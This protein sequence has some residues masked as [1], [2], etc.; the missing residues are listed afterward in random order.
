LEQVATESGQGT[1]FLLQRTIKSYGER[2]IRAPSNLKPGPREKPAPFVIAFI[3]LSFGRKFVCGI[4]LKVLMH[5]SPTA[6]KRVAGRV[7]RERR[8][9]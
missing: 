3:H 4:H 6:R 1:P 9:Y 5:A 7:K 2:E 8:K